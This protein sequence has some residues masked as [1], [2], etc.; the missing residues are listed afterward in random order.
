MALQMRTTRCGVCY[1]Y[2]RIAPA[3]KTAFGKDDAEKQKGTDRFLSVLSLFAERCEKSQS[4]RRVSVQS[5][6][7]WWV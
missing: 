1:K 7:C 6:S 5:F 3:G 4:V 2:P